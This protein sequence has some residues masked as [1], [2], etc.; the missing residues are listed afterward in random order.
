MSM[1]NMLFGPGSDV[2]LAVAGLR[3]EDV[4]RF[5]HSWLERDE[6]SGEVLVALY[7]RNGG[8]NRAECWHESGIYDEPCTVALS[9]EIPEGGQC[10][11]ACVA[12]V[13]LPGLPNF[14]RGEDDDFDRTYRTERF[15]P[16]DGV[17]DDLLAQAVDGTV[18][19][20]EVWR[21]SLD[22]LRERMGAG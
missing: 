12:N 9:H 1:F 22:V 8:G 13:L 11:P 21:E 19:M 16:L 18:D 4:G 20:D 10:C 5:R 15:R 3:K 6:V 7:T 2:P 17:P 14:V